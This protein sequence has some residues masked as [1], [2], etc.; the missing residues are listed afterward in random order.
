MGR[1]PGWRSNA[2]FNCHHWYRYW[3]FCDSSYHWLFPKIRELVP[4]DPMGV[5]LFGKFKLEEDEVLRIKNIYGFQYAY[6]RS[7]NYCRTERYLGRC[8]PDGSPYIK[9][10]KNRSKKKRD[11]N[12]KT[13]MVSIPSFKKDDA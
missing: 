8:N 5:K 11:L 10:L 6:A 13:G 2:S 9:S 7:K 4:Q 1:D 3:G 12:Y